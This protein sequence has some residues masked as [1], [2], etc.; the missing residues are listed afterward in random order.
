MYKNKRSE[1]LYSCLFALRAETYKLTGVMVIVFQSIGPQRLLR[2]G[3]PNPSPDDPFEARLQNIKF[4]TSR[5][6]LGFSTHTDCQPFPIN[7]AT[8]NIPL[9]PVTGIKDIYALKGITSGIIHI[10]LALAIVSTVMLIVT[11]A[12]MVSSHYYTFIQGFRHFGILLKGFVV[13]WSIAA[14]SFLMLPIIFTKQAS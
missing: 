6:C 7:L 1:A 10:S 12:A 3:S 5:C 8:L 4:G 9:G 13:F 2:H 14:C 11:V